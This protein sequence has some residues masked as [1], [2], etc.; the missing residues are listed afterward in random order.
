[1]LAARVRVQA[2]HKVLSL[3]ARASFDDGDI[4]KLKPGH[5]DAPFEGLLD[6]GLFP[7]PGS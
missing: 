3:A 7:P 4:L 5:G 6:L 2:V 1:M